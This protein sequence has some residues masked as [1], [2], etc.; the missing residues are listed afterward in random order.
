MNGVRASNNVF[1]D[2]LYFDL[3]FQLS[4]NTTPHCV[5]WEE[6]DGLGYWSDKGCYAHWFNI[7]HV[8]CQCNH[9]TNFAILM[10]VNDFPHELSV[11]LVILSNA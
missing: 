2:K 11:S 1:V 8:T 4:T 5:F 6:E 10:S 7:S 9:L 3:Y